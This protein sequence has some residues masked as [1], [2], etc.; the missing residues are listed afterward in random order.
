[1]HPAFWYL[2]VGGFVIA[3]ILLIR[4]LRDMRRRR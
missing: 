2:I 3:T 4:S 1:V